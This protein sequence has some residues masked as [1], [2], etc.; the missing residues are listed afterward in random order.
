MTIPRLTEGQ[1]GVLTSS[2]KS[3]PLHK[4][5]EYSSHSL[6]YEMTHP[7]KHWQ[8]HTPELLHFFKMAYSR[9]VFPPWMDLPSLHRDLLLSPCLCES[10]V[11]TSAI[12]GT[13]MWPG[14]RP[15]S[16]NHSLS[17]HCCHLLPASEITGALKYHRLFSLVTVSFAVQKLCSLMDPTVLVLFLWLL[18]FMSS[19][20][21]SLWR[22]M[23]KNF[24]PMLSFRSFVV[25]GL[26][27]KPLI[28]FG[29]NFL[30]GIRDFSCSIRI[31]PVL[32]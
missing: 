25:S 1:S 30:Y 17:Q 11:P 5:M 28:Y 4:N 22:P 29:V 8:P 27:C 20:K 14:M 32:C 23:P 6:G 24:P 7:Y 31:E 2:W 12:P 16:L 13:R 26:M 19:S 10:Q 18:L 9:S 15:S 3:P 21:P